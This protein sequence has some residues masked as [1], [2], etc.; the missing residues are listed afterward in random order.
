MPVCS[1]TLVVLTGGSVLDTGRPP[2]SLSVTLAGSLCHHFAV[3]QIEE[4]KREMEEATEIA[5]AV[6]ADLKV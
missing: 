4:L 5:D 2:H 1:C 3:T 6:R